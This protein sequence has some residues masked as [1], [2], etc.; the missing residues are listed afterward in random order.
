[1]FNLS[2]V[3]FAEAKAASEAGLKVRLV[4]REGNKPVSNHAMLK[5]GSIRSFDELFQKEDEK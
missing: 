4:V 5:Y 2:N 1:M 3:K